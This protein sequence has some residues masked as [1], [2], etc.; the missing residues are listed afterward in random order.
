MAMKHRFRVL[1]VFRGI[2]ASIIVFAHMSYYSNT[3][4][5]NNEFVNNA[6]VFVDFFFVLSGFVI[7]YSYQ[8]IASKNE[9]S[10]FFAKRF[11][12]IYPLH[13]ILLITYVLIEL[14]KFF[15]KNHIQINSPFD[16]SIQTFVTNLFLLNS[17][18]FPGI[19]DFSWNGVSWSIS[20]EFISYVA[21]ALIIYAITISRFSKLKPLATVSTSILSFGILVLITNAYKIDY[22]YNYGFLRGLIGFFCGAFCFY[23]FEHFYDRVKKLSAN[24]FTVLEILVITSVILVVYNGKMVYANGYIYEFLFFIAIFVFAFEKGQVSALLNKSKFL[25]NIGKYSYSIYMVHTLILTIM[26]VVFI[27]IFKLPNTA[28]TYLFAVNYG[29]V[30]F[31]S[32]WTYKNIE[33]RFKDIF[34]KKNKEVKVASV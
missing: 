17:I 20:A 10:T 31:V 33:I 14:V 3:P 4:I 30:Y 23:V 29:I 22:G 24:L 8:S 18:K 2:F 5:L 28:Y 12:R 1:D 16:N 11:A 21:Y 19:D 7:C 13:F 26:D 9:L 27:R 25:S 32:A 6:G 34:I 15:A